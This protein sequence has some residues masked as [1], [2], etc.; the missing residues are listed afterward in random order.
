MA[1]APALK[2]FLLGASEKNFSIDFSVRYIMLYKAQEESHWF[3][4]HNFLCAILRGNVTHLRHI[5]LSIFT[6]PS[7]CT[8]Y[9]VQTQCLLFLSMSVKCFQKVTMLKDLT[10]ENFSARTCQMKSTG[11]CESFYLARD[12]QKMNVEK[13]PIHVFK[14]DSKKDGHLGFLQSAWYFTF[15]QE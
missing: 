3:S 12:W 1:S 13:I 6:P 7:T 15:F 10:V 2:S 8:S 9:P 4:V 14:L 11:R 5:W